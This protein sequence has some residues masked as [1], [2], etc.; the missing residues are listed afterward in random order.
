[1]AEVRLA[2]AVVGAGQSSVLGSVRLARPRT[3]LGRNHVRFSSAKQAG[4]T[5]RLR[6]PFAAPV[7]AQL[8]RG[9]SPTVRDSLGL[10]AAPASPFLSLAQVSR[11]H[12]RETRMPDRPS[13]KFSIA[14]TFYRIQGRGALA[15]LE[16]LGG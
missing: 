10:S 16:I 4:L 7:A 5:A 11:R 6:K 12:V 1:M 3:R 8:P 9:S 14:Q 13:F 15:E 2:W